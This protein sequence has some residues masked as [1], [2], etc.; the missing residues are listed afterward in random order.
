MNDKKILLVDDTAFMRMLIK[1]ILLKNNF[2][3]CGEAVD[4]LD[5]VKKYKEFQ[6]DLVIMDITMPNM[7]GLEAL[8]TIK[9]QYIKAKIIMCSAMGQEFHVREAI[10]LGATDFIIKPFEHDRVIST[11]TRALS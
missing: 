11:V 10:K 3:I 2:N 8:R 9:N 6:P 4:G 1:G 7:D 5:A